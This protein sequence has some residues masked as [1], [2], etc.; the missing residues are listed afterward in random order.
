MTNTAFTVNASVGINDSVGVGVGANVSAS[1]NVTENLS[2]TLTPT[3]SGCATSSPVLLNGNDGR[4]PAMGNV[5]YCNC[6]AALPVTTHSEPTLNGP[7]SRPSN[8]S[9]KAGCVPQIVNSN[10]HLIELLF[11]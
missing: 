5:C 4:Q 3:T 9:F 1:V 7:N 2:W 8:W 6:D 10:T 11:K